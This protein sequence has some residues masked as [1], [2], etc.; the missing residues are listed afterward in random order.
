MSVN[1]LRRPLKKKVSA[2]L[3]LFRLFFF[4]VA[5]AIVHL[6]DSFLPLLT[7]VRQSAD[8]FGDR[9]GKPR[10]IE[11]DDVRVRLA[12]RR[13]ALHHASRNADHRRVRR[14]GTD[15]DGA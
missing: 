12:P 11:I 2:H 10:M 6:V 1:R 8:R 15:D 9:V 5:L 14:N 7:I 4:E 3:R 13:F